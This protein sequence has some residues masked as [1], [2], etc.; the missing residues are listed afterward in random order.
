M[1]DRSGLLCQPGM[2]QACPDC[3]DGADLESV[4]LP[5]IKETAE[6]AANGP[7]QDVTAHANGEALPTRTEEGLVAGAVAPAPFGAAA[8]I[9]P[10]HA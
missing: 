1:Q 9:F 8:G 2:R 4:K 7:Q 3:G 10:A 6:E 5:G